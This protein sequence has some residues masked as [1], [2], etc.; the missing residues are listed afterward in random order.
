MFRSQVMAPCLAG[1]GAPQVDGALESPTQWCV[2]RNGTATWAGEDART[3]RSS[4]TAE[5]RIRPSDDNDLVG[6]SQGR[7]G[8][9]PPGTGRIAATDRAHIV[10]A[11]L[12]SLGGRALLEVHSQRLVSEGVD[13]VEGREMYP[14]TLLD[15]ARAFQVAF[16]DLVRAGTLPTPPIVLYP[17]PFG[18]G[19]LL[20]KF[21]AAVQPVGLRATRAR[22][23]RFLVALLEA[24]PFLG[25]GVLL[26]LGIGLRDRCHHSDGSFPPP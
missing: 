15:A 5:G 1:L 2:Q 21:R 23:W 12:P 20:F 19:V 10:C 3:V 18:C 7:E 6:R 8:H 11:A 24:A 26:C 13:V 22:R 16:L 4:L 25:A 9:P 14:T 17:L